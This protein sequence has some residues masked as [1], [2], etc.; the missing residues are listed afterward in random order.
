VKHSG[1][2]GLVEVTPEHMTRLPRRWS[3]NLETAS[4][5]CVARTGGRRGRRKS[6]TRCSAAHPSKRRPRDE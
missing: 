3:K 6:S 4:G 1:L 2:E 5:S